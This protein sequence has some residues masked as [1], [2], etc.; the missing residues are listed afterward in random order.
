[1]SEPKMEERWVVTVKGRARECRFVNDEFIHVTNSAWKI[2][3]Y[4]P[5]IQSAKRMGSVVKLDD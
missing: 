4:D 5:E 1:M 2:S 3:A